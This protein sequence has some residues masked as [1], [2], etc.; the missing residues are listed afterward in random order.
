VGAAIW[1]LL[2]TPAAGAEIAGALRTLFPD[3]PQETID[4]D[5]AA[6]IGVLLSRGLVARA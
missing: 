5:T 1:L 6:L 4:R 3:V 2:E